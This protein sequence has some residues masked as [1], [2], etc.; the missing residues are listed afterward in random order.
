MS[1]S[2]R[3]ALAAAR[4][5]AVLWAN[6]R[7]SAPAF[8]VPAYLAQQGYRVYPIHPA[9]VHA[10]K[11]LWG[12]PMLQRLD[13]VPEP[14]AWRPTFPD[15]LFLSVTTATSFAPADTLPMRH[16][17]KALM[18]IEAMLSL[19]VLLIIAARAISILD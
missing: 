13:Q 6:P 9:P 15:Y 8:Y 1:T 7:P 5:I 4:T 3:A 14:V 2:P 16:R 19:L 10:D 17:V 12:R 18:A 11:V